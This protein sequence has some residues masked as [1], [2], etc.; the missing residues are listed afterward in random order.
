MIGRR[1]LLI[2]LG[3]LIAAPAIARADNLMQ[4]RGIILRPAC[5]RLRH[6]ISN[7]EIDIGYVNGGLDVMAMRRFLDTEFGHIVSWYDQSGNGVSCSGIVVSPCLWYNNDP[8][9]FF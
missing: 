4:L 7:Q 1:K 6:P 3:A 2:G 5:L 8:A 9:Y